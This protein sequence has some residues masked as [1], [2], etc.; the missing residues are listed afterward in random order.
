[1]AKIWTVLAV[2]LIAVFAAG[3][4]CGGGG[5]GRK[6]GPAVVLVDPDEDRREPVAEVEPNETRES[7]QAIPA[8]RPV[9]GAVGPATK[10]ND[11]DWYRVTAPTG[12]SDR[13]LKATITGATD[14]DLTLEAFDEEGV[15][16]VRVNNTQRGGG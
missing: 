16:L 8:E 13:L 2:I 4:T 15:R 14:L 10:G 5:K 12:G 3:C 6:K 1:M 9:A 7:A 11:Q